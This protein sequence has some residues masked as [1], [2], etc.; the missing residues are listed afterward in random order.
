VF[1]AADGRLGSLAKLAFEVSHMR[2]SRLQLM[3]RVIQLL[4]ELGDFSG[5][6][7]KSIFVRSLPFC[8]LVFHLPV[9]GHQLTVL[10]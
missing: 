7:A 10:H 6:S 2:T 5:S 1:E 3:I 8:T 9:E 4:A